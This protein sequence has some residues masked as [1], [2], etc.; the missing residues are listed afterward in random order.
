MQYN[1]HSILFEEII[2]ANNYINL[3]NNEEEKLMDERVQN[4]QD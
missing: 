1:Q 3:I 2:D 4:L